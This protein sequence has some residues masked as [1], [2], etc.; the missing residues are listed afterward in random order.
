[1]KNGEAQ[2]TSPS[3]VLSASVKRPPFF[4]LSGVHGLMPM[5]SAAIS[6]A[7]ISKRCVPIQSR[8]GAW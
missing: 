2:K 4:H 8:M 7:K 3:A 1:M 5:A 6:S